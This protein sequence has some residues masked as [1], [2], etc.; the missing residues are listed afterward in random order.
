MIVDGLLF[1]F[2]AALA[3]LVSL[4]PASA[5]P[6]F[7]AP[8]GSL[9]SGIAAV[10]DYMGPVSAWVPFDAVAVVLPAVLASLAFSLTV[11]A[12]RFVMSLVSGGG[13]E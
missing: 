1:A 9:H 12:I 8:G 3:G 11:R 2:F 6:A 10:V 4:F 7:M 13:G 5:L